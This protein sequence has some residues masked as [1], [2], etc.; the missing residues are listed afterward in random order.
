MKLQGIVEK[1][2]WLIVIKDSIANFHVIPILY[3]LEGTQ[4]VT[5][6]P[7][8][9]RFFQFCHKTKNQFLAKEIFSP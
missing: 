5:T 6:M 1:N 4:L 9:I 8:H 3:E 2:N 7:C